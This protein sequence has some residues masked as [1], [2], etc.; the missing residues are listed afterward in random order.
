MGVN[1]DFLPGGAVQFT[2][3]IAW[4]KIVYSTQ[5]FSGVVPVLAAC[6]QVTAGSSP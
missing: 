1:N 3:L 5:H 4:R 2:R 6:W